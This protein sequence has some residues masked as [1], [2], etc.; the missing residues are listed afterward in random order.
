MF[1]YTEFLPRAGISDIAQSFC[2]IDIT[3]FCGHLMHEF[4]G[5]SVDQINQVSRL[6]FMQQM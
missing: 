6:K 2:S 3:N 1:E 5:Q 4:F